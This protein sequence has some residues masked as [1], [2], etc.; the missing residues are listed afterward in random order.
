[1]YPS[2]VVISLWVTDIGLV[3]CDIHRHSLLGMLPHKLRV[4]LQRHRLFG[5]ST[6]KGCAGLRCCRSKMSVWNLSFDTNLKSFTNIT[7]ASEEFASSLCSSAGINLNLAP[8]PESLS[9]TAAAA[10]NE[11]TSAAAVASPAGSAIASIE[12]PGA[13]AASVPAA[14]TAP[15]YS[16]TPT[17][18]TDSAIIVVDPLRFSLS[19][20][21]ASPS[22]S[23][24]PKSLLSLVETAASAVSSIPTTVSLLSCSK[25]RTSRFRRYHLRCASLSLVI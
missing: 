25:K 21:V 2:P 19:D 6:G 9:S 8:P 23:A 12:S 3:I 4:Y 11:P 18:S 17:V 14:A 22:H 24:L 1:M 15:V 13:N 7:I 16:A 5:G 10:A 20:I